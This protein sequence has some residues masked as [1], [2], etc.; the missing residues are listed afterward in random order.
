[1]ESNS[2]LFNKHDRKNFYSQ[3][4]EDIYVYLNYI[5]I[6]NKDGVF[7]EL[8]GFDGI[9]YSNTKFFEDEL[10]FKGILIEPTQQFKKLVLNR[11]SCKN[12]NLAVS[13]TTGP[14]QIIGES[15]TASLLDTAHQDFI[16]KYHKQSR[17]Y[18]VDG[19]PFYDILKDSGISRID[20]LSI[21][22][23]G[24]ELTVLETMDF[25]I[26][27]YVVVLES[28]GH[29]PEKDEQCRNILKKNG[30]I[31][32][33]HFCLNDVW[34]NPSYPFISSVFSGKKN[35]NFMRLSDFGNFPF[36]EKHCV[37]DVENALRS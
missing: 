23:E 33:K 14:V 35:E 25:S 26:P 12:Y 10:K 19:K 9:T 31:F 6:P 2:K 7:I 13:K 20:L 17:K 29:N 11:P 1:M 5:N 22:V 30:F 24:G 18:S 27:T 28:D 21:D 15:A 4:G 3:Q 8:G 36:L 32:D 16:N 37:A 34:Y